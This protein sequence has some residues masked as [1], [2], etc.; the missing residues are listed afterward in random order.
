MTKTIAKKDLYRQLKEVSDDVV[1]NGTVYVVI[2]NSKPAFNIVPIEIKQKKKYRKE[3]IFKFMFTGK[4][5]KE[6]NLA[7]NYKK[8]LY[9]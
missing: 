4:D 8:Y 5:K 6:R 9:G 2:Q 7:L 1:K 3:D